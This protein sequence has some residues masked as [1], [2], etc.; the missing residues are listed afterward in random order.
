M[1]FNT[2]FALGTLFLLSGCSLFQNKS[3]SLKYSASDLNAKWNILSIENKA[4]DQKVNGKEPLLNFDL[5]KKEYSAITGCNNLMG[6]FELKAPNKIKFSQGMSTMMACENM[7]VEQ[8]LS[9][10]FPLVS[11]YKISNDTLSF[12]DA[13][14]GIKAQFKLKKEDKSSQ[15]EGKWELDYIGLTNQNLEQLFQAKKPTLEFN[16]KEGTLVGN[17]GCNNYSGTFQNDGHKLK[18][19]AIASTKM[20]CPSMQGESIYFKNLAKISSFSVNDDQ[21]T[22]I[23]DDI[24]ILRFKIVK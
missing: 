16:T 15:L 7:E 24:A 22:L 12:L 3:Q 2:L 1:K 5:A 11:T 8:G 23:T 19:G 20:A 9:R 13:K 17:G 10:I 21:L 18:F 6:G 14:K 4:V